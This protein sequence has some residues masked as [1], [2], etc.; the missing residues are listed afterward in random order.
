MNIFQNTHTIFPDSEHEQ[1][2]AQLLALAG[3]PGDNANANANANGRTFVPNSAIISDDSYCSSQQQPKLIKT[4]FDA[5]FQTNPPERILERNSSLGLGQ[6]SAT[7]AHQHQHQMHQT[8][9]A[10]AD[11]SAS[12]HQLSFVGGASVSA[13]AYPPSYNFEPYSTSATTYKEAYAN[14]PASAFNCETSNTYENSVVSVSN[15]TRTDNEVAGDIQH[16]VTPPC[17][18]PPALEIFQPCLNDH[19]V[20]QSVTT[21][22]VTSTGAG[23]GTVSQSHHHPMQSDH[24]HQAPY[25]PTYYSQDFPDM[26]NLPAS[27]NHHPYYQSNQQYYQQQSWGNEKSVQDCYNPQQQPDYHV[28]NGDS[29]KQQQQQLGGTSSTNKRSYHSNA[30]PVE[31][32]QVQRRKPPRKRV[33]RSDDMPRYPLSAYNFFFS[34]ERE[35][36]LALL[37][38]PAKDYDTIPDA[39][40]CASIDTSDTNT[41]CT[42]SSSSVAQDTD[43][44]EKDEHQNAIPEFK[45]QEEEFNYVQGILST[46]KMS[47]AKMDELQTKIKT[48]T[49][50]KL[51][52]LLE[53]DKVKKSHK[54]SHGKITFQVLS[55]LIGQRWRDI[56]NADSKQYYFDLAKKDQERYNA[57]MKEY[58][59]LGKVQN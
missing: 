23:P 44:K 20:S 27:Y 52:T 7:N 32:A 59:K 10:A 35:V 56:S 17:S 26:S 28:S 50:R 49:Q 6:Y 33:K 31:G 21:V 9:V 55:R 29:Y 16:L 19:N 37:S 58:K 8:A 43:T 5:L 40:P 42:T 47:E 34:E 24:Q 39:A 2:S 11:S 41:T 38:A 14:T 51:N 53:G 48:N 12:Q 46:R 13:I 1:H 30:V 18:S 57:Q 3:G 45:N 4:D 25:V 15:V 36:A 54:K 22:N